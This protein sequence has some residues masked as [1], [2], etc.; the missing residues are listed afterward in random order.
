ME[1]FPGY[2]TL[3]DEDPTD[4]ARNLE[5]ELMN[6]I[7]GRGLC[8]PTRDESRMMRTILAR[9]KWMKK[10][11]KKYEELGPKGH[12]RDIMAKILQPWH[13]KSAME[14]PPEDIRPSGPYPRK[15]LLLS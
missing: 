11:D 12:C 6:L 3:E 5:W 7:N 10:W 9:T 4:A 1:F 8:D 14:E 15:G 13:P 2:K